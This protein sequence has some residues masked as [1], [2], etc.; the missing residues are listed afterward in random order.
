MIQPRSIS[1]LRG[2]AV[3]AV[4]AVMSAFCS[5]LAAG[6]AI[7]PDVPAI[8]LGEVMTIAVDV[9]GDWTPETLPMDDGGFGPVADD[10]PNFGFARDVFW[11]RLELD[12]PAETDAERLLVMDYPLLDEVR[13]YQRE[14]DA[15]RVQRSGDTVPVSER[16]LAHRS[17]VF[18]VLL[19]AR[20]EATLLLRVATES[21]VQLG[22]TLYTP[23]G[24]AAHLK[25]ETAALGAWY[26][27]MLAMLC[28]NLFIACSV[29]DRSYVTYCVYLSVFLLCQMSLNGLA[30][31]LL[32]PEWTWWGNRATPFLIGASI[33][34]ILFFSTSF[35]RTAA[36]APR[37][38]RF[39]TRG[40]VCAP[41]ALMVVSLTAPYWFSI[42]M[43]VVLMVPL[44]GVALLAGIWTWRQ[45]YRPGL[46][47]T[48]AWTGFL[49]GI[50]VVSLKNAGLL[51]AN[52]LT[53]YA[54]QMGSALEVVLLSLGLA[55]RINLI[56]REKQRYAREVTQ[57]NQQLEREVATRRETERQLAKARDQLEAK[58]AERTRELG[59]A[60]ASLEE[61]IANHELTES[62]LRVSQWEAESA[63]Q[64]KA[65]L[66]THIT[67]EIRNPLNA[68]IG[69][70]NLLERGADLV[71]VGEIRRKYLENIRVS[72]EHLA[73]ILNQVLELSPG[74]QLPETRLEPKTKART[75]RFAEGQRVLVVEDNDINAEVMGAMLRNLGLV[76]ERARDG[77][78]AVALFHGS[79]FDLILMDLH[80]PR[81]DGIQATVRIRAE[82]SAIPILIVSADTTDEQRSGAAAAGATD[83]VLKPVP[84]REMAAILERYLRLSAPKPEAS[85]DSM[86]T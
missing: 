3:V 43:A 4:C 85:S 56:N 79:R 86:V 65:A 39:L 64:A 81:M 41:L 59:R 77:V 83:F 9:A 12:N 23:L 84:L 30:Q 26:G 38:D 52:F 49:A 51:P 58:V 14:G 37:L 7:D 45:G 60:V 21:S 80:M 70:T 18:P 5:S 22:A 82:D 46:F 33:L 35:L 50:A 25:R 17:A 53:D 44:C 27:I 19:P 1:E 55:D 32:W 57:T 42:R 75:P 68:I 2:C 31:V 73:E 63:N 10:H 20:S 8:R 6:T 74:E 13:L 67:K 11:I 29:R 72:G 40:L 16:P 76:S 61:E 54:A 36:F 34:A 78:D 71:D 47:F 24:Y 69:F 48:L 62:R 15:W 66:L 28:Y